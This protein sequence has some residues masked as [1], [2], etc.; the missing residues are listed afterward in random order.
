MPKDGNLFDYYIEKLVDKKI[1][2]KVRKVLKTYRYALC[3][4]NAAVSDEILTPVRLDSVE[5]SKWPQ[6]KMWVIMKGIYDKYRG[7]CVL[8]ILVALQSAG[9]HTAN[10]NRQ[11]RASQSGQLAL[12]PKSHPTNFQDPNGQNRAPPD[13]RVSDP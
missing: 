5:K 4:L 11:K 1:A 3:A 7:D 8:T 6:R 13:R 2:R 9:A 10:K 12:R